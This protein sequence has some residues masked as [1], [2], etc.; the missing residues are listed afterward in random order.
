[1]FFLR[2][3]WYE[4]Q[5]YVNSHQMTIDSILNQQKSIDNRFAF[6][7]LDIEDI[8]TFVSQQLCDVFVRSSICGAKFTS[9]HLKLYQFSITMLTQILRILPDLDSLTIMSEIPEDTKLLSEEQDD[10]FRY[11]STSNIITKVNLEQIS[12]L[13]QIHILLNLCP[14]IRNLQV[15]CRKF[16][17]AE[18]LIRYILTKQNTNFVP[19]LYLICIWISAA[20]DKIMNNL[21]RIII[22]EKL[23]ENF[24]IKRICDRIYF[25]WN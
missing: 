11:I 14:R 12:E 3:Q 7:H 13:D 4:L 21:Q 18:W 5:D 9:L 23:I 20:D 22:N 16:A 24:S 15:K 17:D 8:Y 25:Q 1:M 2:K 6:L 10:M 19:H